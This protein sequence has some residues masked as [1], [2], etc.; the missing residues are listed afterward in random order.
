[1]PGQDLIDVGD[2]ANS[3]TD[4]VTAAQFA[5]DCEVEQGNIADSMS[6]LKVDPD[7]PNVFGAERWF[8]ADQLAFV[9][10]LMGLFGL[11]GTLPQERW[12]FHFE[13]TLR[14]RFT[15]VPIVATGAFPTG[16][17]RLVH[18]ETCWMGNGGVSADAV[19]GGFR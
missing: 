6:V 11:Y 17:T 14:P 3:Q 7:G 1:V 12:E 10:R 13:T 2:I 4:K 19:A 15:I 18:A 5:V 16:V 9:P 8:L